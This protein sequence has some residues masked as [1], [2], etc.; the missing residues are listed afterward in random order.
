MSYLAYYNFS[1][2]HDEEEPTRNAM[3]YKLAGLYDQSL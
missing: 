2:L 1:P 3:T